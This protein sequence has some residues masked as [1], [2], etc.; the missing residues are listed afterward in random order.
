ME[1]DPG[2]VARTL[3]AC[4]CASLSCGI[5]AAKLAKAQRSFVAH[6]DGSTFSDGASYRNEPALLQME[7]QA[8]IGSTV[9]KLRGLQEGL[10]LSGIRFSYF[11]ALYESGPVIEKNGDVIQLPIFPAVRAKIPAG[12][13]LNV[14]EPTCLMHLASDNQMD[15]EFGLSPVTNKSLSF[16]EAIDYWDEEAAS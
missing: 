5:A 3:R 12:A 11:H 4:D 13:L 7:E 2:C 8:Q 6:S 10:S 1:C 14:S 15:M 16:V 9:V